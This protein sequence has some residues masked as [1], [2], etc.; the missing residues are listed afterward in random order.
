MHTH[1]VTT[2]VPT[3]PLDWRADFELVGTLPPA[4]KR[5]GRRNANQLGN[6]TS[7]ARQSRGSV[8]THTVIT[9]VST[10]L[11]GWD[12]SLLSCRIGW[13]FAARRVSQ[14]AVTRQPIRQLR[15]LALLANPR[16]RKLSSL[17][18]GFRLCVARAPR[19]QAGCGPTRWGRPLV[20]RP[21]AERE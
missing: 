14:R 15:K 10:E 6:H 18:S 7:S 2:Q 20:Y 9:E 21:S 19:G 1:T 11:L 13:H 3:D 8:G 17:D 12:G 4:E 5:N 16:A